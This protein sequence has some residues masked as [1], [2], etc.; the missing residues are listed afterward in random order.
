MSDSTIVIESGHTWYERSGD[1]WTLYTKNGGNGVIESR[2][3]AALRS[4][5]PVWA[6]LNAA[7]VL[8]QRVQ[9]L[10]AEREDVQRVEADIRSNAL[11]RLMVDSLGN[12]AMFTYGNAKF[13]SADSLAALGRMLKEGE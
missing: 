12:M 6:I 5:V 9:E 11:H 4:H 1:I 13:A 7:D 10:E 8:Q 2:A 3:V